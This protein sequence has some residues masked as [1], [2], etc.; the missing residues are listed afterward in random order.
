MNKFSY[1][2]LTP[3][4]WFVLE[5]FPFIEADF[6][7]LTDWQ[8]Y[9]KLGKEINKIIDS[10]NVVGTQMENVTNAFIELQNYVDNYF[11]NLDVQDEI[12]NKLNKMAEDGTLQEIISAYLNSKAIFGFDT[13]EEMKNATNLIDGSYAKTLGYYEI[14]DGGAGLYK[15]IKSDLEDNGGNIHVLN[16]GLRA[17]LVDDNINVKQFGAKGDGITDDTVSIQNAINFN[18]KKD[19]R[20][21]IPSGKYVVS[22]TI[23]M[24]AKVGIEGIDSPSILYTGTDICFNITGW[25]REIEGDSSTNKDRNPIIKN[26][27]IDGSS[28][29]NNYNDETTWNKIAIN[30]LSTENEWL[31]RCY[32]EQVKIRNFDKGIVF[33]GYNQY[34]ISFDKCHIYK[35]NIGVDFNK[36]VV[37][38]GE[39]I[40]F[41]DSIISDNRIAFDFKSEGYDVYINNCSID[42]NLCCF[43]DID[44]SGRRYIIMSNS[45]YETKTR[46]ISDNTAHGLIYGYLNNTVLELIGNCIFTDPSEKQ[47][48]N[49]GVT[50][51]RNTIVRATNN[52]F[53]F[54]PDQYNNV[55]T[56]PFMFP[57]FGYNTI[58]SNNAWGRDNMGKALN[59]RLNKLKHGAFGN[60]VTGVAS[61]N[62]STHIVDSNSTESNWRINAQD[63]VK[64]YK[65]IDNNE[66]STK[67]LVAIPENT[68][69]SSSISIATLE[70]INIDPSRPFYISVYAKN[71]TKIEYGY[72]YYL[73]EVWKGRINS[74]VV[75]VTDNE[76]DTLIVPLRAYA[77][78][79]PIDCNQ[80]VPTIKL[81]NSNGMEGKNIEFSA[82]YVYEF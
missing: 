5:N 70:K 56:D 67:S 57:S 71:C 54:W 27:L 77:E 3:F 21:I 16:N 22:S 40:S 25:E 42:Y 55:R 73:D 41:N 28:K 23:N 50:L 24:S 74:H 52:N 39:R 66:L 19:K 36:N 68:N 4:K 46:N 35:N 8:L 6:D 9:C 32:F 18:Q 76:A 1:K 80:F 37:N 61:L 33:N 59:K 64:S 45:H 11:D 34:I 43:R 81:S 62:S 47:T 7:A 38:S 31:A 53:L 20:V 82:C 29:S 30:L 2:N 48:Y 58:F 60:C 75:N 14:N 65:I 17:E 63:N 13:V 79:I 12:N 78:N 51:K 44:G 72:D 26:I 15:I 49:P 69:N 10:Q